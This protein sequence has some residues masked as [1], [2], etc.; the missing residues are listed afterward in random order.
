MI[1]FIFFG[2]WQIAALCKDKRRGGT[3]QNMIQEQC[4]KRCCIKYG[5]LTT[6]KL[7]SQLMQIKLEVSK[8]FF[9]WS[10]QRKKLF[11]PRNRMLIENSEKAAS[12]DIFFRWRMDDA[13]QLG[14]DLVLCWNQFI[15]YFFLLF[16]STDESTWA[17]IHPLC[18]LVCGWILQIIN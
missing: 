1:L 18:H 5:A 9:Y 8:G 16:N 10:I 15:I 12:A 7:S 6:E 11:H 17:P 4:C 3:A 2:E 14:L 13:S